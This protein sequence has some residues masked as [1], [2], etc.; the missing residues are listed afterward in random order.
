MS[1]AN[2]FV[3]LHVQTEYSLSNSV[4]RIKGLMSAV[5]ERGMAAVA[6]TDRCNI[7]A[8][9][10]FFKAAIEQG[11]KP[12]IGVDLPIVR[13]DQQGRTHRLTLLTMDRDG[14][15]NLCELVTEAYA[16]QQDYGVP[17]LARE[18]LS[19]RTR[20][21]IALSGAQEG[22]LGQA[23]TSG[24][25]RKRVDGLLSAY[26][27]LF[28]DRFYI[29]TRRVGLPGEGEYNEAALHTARRGGLPVVATNSVQFI[30]PS[31]HEYH[32]VRVCIHDGRILN[33]SRRPTKYTDQQ[34]LRTPA[35]MQALFSDCPEA[36]ANSVEIAKRCN[37]ALEFGDYFLPHFTV[38]EGRT[39][40]SYLAE[41]AREGLAR[42]LSD[43][44]D[45]DRAEYE[46]RLEKELGV[47]NQMG[48]PGYF[49][50]VADFITW[51]KQNDIPV[52]PGRGSGAGSLV[53][54]VLGITELDPIFHGLLF[55]RFLNPERVS[56]PDFDIDFCMAGRDRV[57]EYVADYYGRDKVAQIITYG[58]MAARAVVRDVGRVM[59]LSYGYVDKIAKLVPFQVGMT[60]DV[61]LQQE[62]LLRDRY[63]QDEEVK[64]LIDTAGAL[65]GLARNVGRHAGGV[66]IAPSGLTEFAPLYCERGSEQPLTQFDKDDLEAIGLV[67]FDFLGLRT[68]TIIARAVDRINRRRRNGEGPLVDLDSMPLDD[69]DTYELIKSGRTTSLF[70][71]ESRGMKDLI[72]RLSPDNFQDLVALVALF[73]PGPLQSGMVDDFIDRKH[74][75]QALSYQHPLLE[76]VLRPT[77]GVILYQEQVMEIARVLGGYSLGAADLL[78][79]AM[80]KKKPEEMARQ[81]EVFLNGARDRNV[82]PDTASTIFDLMEKFAGYGFNKSHSAAYALLTYQTAWLK[83]HYPAEFMA[84][85]LSSDMDNTDRVVDLIS[86][87][88]DMGIDV[89]PPNVNTGWYSFETNGEGGILYGLGA[90]KGLGQ[91]VIEAVVEARSEGGPFRDLFDFCERVDPRRLNKR[92][93]ESLICA[94]AADPLGP[95]R[96]ALLATMPTAL[97]LAQQQNRSEGQGELFGEQGGS[98]QVRRFQDVGPWN[99][100]KMLTAERETLGLY[101]SGHPID[102][103]RRYLDQIVDASLRDLK[104]TSDRNVTVGGLISAIRTMNTRRGDRMAFV[105]LDDQTARVELAVFSDLYGEKR[106]AIRKDNLVV[107]YGEVK[108]D[109]YTGGFKMSAEKLYDWDEARLAFTSRVVLRLENGEIRRGRSIDR[110]RELVAEHGR[111]NVPLWIQYANDEAEG[112]LKLGPD[113]HVRP[114]TAFVEALMEAFGDDRVDV[115]FN[116]RIDHTE[117]SD[118]D[119]AA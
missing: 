59:G 85:A 16:R 80:G 36:V 109:E 51:A 99:K 86:D 119:H 102:R 18:S 97:E 57:I 65:E 70:Q 106:E 26:T 50:I 96:A 108:V 114:T 79:R 44:A 22:E 100:E 72:K 27:T 43:A 41:K 110:L 7:Y 42:R 29:E 111:G 116:P 62:E 117:S 88:R 93:L 74:G 61:A 4:L 118:V 37:F 104:P 38:P 63:E 46:A 5:P 23:L 24:A 68:L 48:F 69:P 54:W 94:G 25:N 105:T 89:L 78:R 53:A 56:L 11:I 14:Y 8:A 58:T 1:S 13:L 71:L 3:H 67:K 45:V 49:L 17:A 103:H 87:C 21:L 34:Y 15:R 60:L 77:Y 92:A 10:K 33:D 113:W 55:E 95:H 66:V 84:A 73:R 35:E 19:G 81:R 64:Q 75:R 32:E 112:L 40:E 91:G 83:A 101:F 107:V 9:V 76:P 2:T 90:I 39:A 52:G 31:E 82:D 28:P 30:D 47:I 20:G 98:D 12:I 115:V 6:M